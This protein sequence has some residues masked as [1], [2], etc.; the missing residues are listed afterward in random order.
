MVQRFPVQ[1]DA[2][3]FDRLAR[4]TQPMAGV[5]ELIW[6]ALD[7]EA[8]VV[9]VTVART[10]LDGVDIVQV[11][12]NGH[13]LTH[14]EALRD[15][16][17]L[18]GSWKKSRS[19]S[20]NGTRPLHGKDGAGRFRA[21]AIGSL[22]E[23]TTTTAEIDDSLVRT[24]I[25]GSLDASEFTVS[26]PE[27]LGSGSAG[28]T[29]RI[30]QPREHAHRLLADAASSQVVIQLAVYLI[31]YP[32]VAITY[33]GKTL[34]PKAILERETSIE[35]DS[36]L[37]GHHGAPLLTIMEWRPEAKSI[38]PSL[39]LCDAKGVAL[40]EITEGIDT[41]AG[42]PYTAYLMWPGF[43]ERV[44]ELPLAEFDSETVAPILDAAR[45]AIRDHIDS[46]LSERR[47]EQLERW[48]AERVYPYS[49][50]PQT[51]AEA[52][53]RR[54]FDVVA[55][56]AAPA[57]AREPKA[58]RLSLRLIREALAQPPGALHRVLKEVLDLTG[59]QLADFDHLLERTTLASIIYTN[60]LVTDRLDFLVD[61]ESMLFD[62][63]KKKRLLERSQLHRIIANGKTWIFGEEYGLA[64]DDQGLT[65]VLEAHLSSLGDDR[66]V[67]RP[68]TD[69]EGHTRIV[70]LM[71]SKAAL[72]GDG[73]EHLVVE[74]K[75]PSVSLTQ[76]ELSQITNYA[77]A[78]SED[79]R[80]A[81]PNVRWD[82]WLL[83]DD[84]DHVVENLARTPNR[85][86]GLYTE[87]QNYRIWVRRWAEVL[88][89]NRQRL[90]FF[91][92]HLEYQPQDE[93]ELEGMLSKYL[94]NANPDDRAP[95]EKVGSDGE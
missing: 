59:E 62:A 89:E 26:D 64:V 27:R 61:L 57:V 39:I 24:K 12:D 2:D 31:K 14:A 87:G 1:V 30:A 17:R 6:N 90:H 68:V 88:E 92:E 69:T 35:L 47:V 81:A 49:G 11:Q 95:S 80:F 25:T 73:R 33:D 41:R 10:D 50:Q 76:I 63:D 40:H 94:P 93:A 32:Q 84:M 72:R 86:T 13:G 9:T 56:A 23:W 79:E 83:G 28:T 8:D 19:V 48:K 82:F 91:R 37:G 60:K 34:D 70:D 36:A 71:L 75:R 74:L 66:P 22:V 85:P 38:K 16:R 53:E 43:A 67:L 18:G 5:V 4:P 54:V 77:V 29:V 78:V 15:F 51:Q 21:F 45:A 7:A 65:K 58:A 44:N 3:Q 20:K 46:R 55:T 52:N 42:L